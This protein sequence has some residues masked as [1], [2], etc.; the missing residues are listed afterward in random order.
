MKKIFGLIFICS[1]LSFYVASG[2]K[3]LAVMASDSPA[4]AAASSQK[5][6]DGQNEDISEA[7]SDLL[8][9]TDVQSPKR[10]YL[11]V[12]SGIGSDHWSRFVDTSLN[13]TSQ[14]LTRVDYSFTV[15]YGG[16]LGVV[17]NPLFQAELTVFSMPS[18]TLHLSDGR[19]ERVSLYNVA[20][21]GRMNVD[22]AGVHFYTKAGGAFRKQHFSG[23]MSDRSQFSP[24]FGLG[25]VYRFSPSFSFGVDYTHFMNTTSRRNPNDMP[26]QDMLVLGLE[27]YFH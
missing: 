16:K 15:A 7:S 27:Y 1:L 21:L 9:D 8:D 20:M 22:I 2:A 18:N 26:S 24:V 25:D 4:L 11:G 3:D 17:F 10:L 12:F 13:Q 19:V 14:I 5:D 6:A 23:A